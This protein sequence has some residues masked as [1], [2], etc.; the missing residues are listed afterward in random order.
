MFFL[1]FRFNAL[2]RV[3]VSHLWFYRLFYTIKLFLFK[4]INRKYKQNSSWN[5]KWRK[6]Q[7]TCWLNRSWASWWWQT[8]HSV[9]ADLKKERAGHDGLKGFTGKT[10]TFFRYLI[11]DWTKVSF[12]LW[13]CF[14]LFSVIQIRRI[15][16]SC[17][18]EAQ[19][20]DCS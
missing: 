7:L 12:F 16:N 3:G 15:S 10:G 8:S 9:A 1:H 2:I 18:P 17:E 4:V 19:S 6:S 13:T 11:R 20:S 5:N 14:S